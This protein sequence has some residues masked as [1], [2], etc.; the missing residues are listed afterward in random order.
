MK[1][2]S[3]SRSTSS[4]IWTGISI[5]SIRKSHQT[6]GV[7]MLGTSKITF[8]SQTTSRIKK[9][10][11]K[12]NCLKTLCSS[13]LQVREKK[14]P[15]S[16]QII[17]SAHKRFRSSGNTISLAVLLVSIGIILA[18]PFPLIWQ[19][20]SCF[21]FDVLLVFC[22]CIKFVILSFTVFVFGLKMVKCIII[23]E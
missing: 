3:S 23:A 13:L 19:G 16:M 8:Q 14:D 17:I 11:Q 21:A 20:R 22:V 2:S 5:S 12:W 7:Y 10:L 1:R 4:I 6:K 18:I 9:I 15:E